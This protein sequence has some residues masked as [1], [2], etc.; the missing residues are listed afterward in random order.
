MPSPFQVTVSAST[1]Q[2]MGVSSATSSQAQ[3]TCAQ[4]LLLSPQQAA[5][6]HGRL[7]S[8]PSQHRGQRSTQGRSGGRNQLPICWC[9]R[10]AGSLGALRGSAEAPL[11]LSTATSW[12]TGRSG[13]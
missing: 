5:H 12:L 6:Q 3:R 11:R 7:I 1:C 2:R 9:E 13:P 8:R 10:M 4:A